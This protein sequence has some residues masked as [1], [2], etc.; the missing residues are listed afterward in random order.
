MHSLPHFPWFYL[1]NDIWG[2]VESMKLMLR[3]YIGLYLT[4]KHFD[5][6]ENV[7]VFKTLV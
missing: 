7:S 4:V 3:V 1:P 6:S 5:K 2:W